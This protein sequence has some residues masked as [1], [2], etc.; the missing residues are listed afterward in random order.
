MQYI[1]NLLL[2]G[3]FI[4]S[5]AKNP[6][7]AVTI[8]EVFQTD[9]DETLDMDSP[10]VWHG[11]NGENWIITTAKKG[12]SLYVNDANSG[13]LVKM[14]GEK[15]T[16][17]NQFRRP[18]GIF[19]FEDHVFIVERDNRRVQVMALPSF[20]SIGVTGDSLLIKPYGLYI[21]QDSLK[22][23]HLYVTDNYETADEQ[24]PPISELDRRVHHYIFSIAG[25]TL[26]SQLVG[27]FGDTTETGALS[28]VESIHGDP[29][30]D[31]LLLSE[32]D[33]SQNVVKVYNINGKFTGKSFGQ[34]IFMSQ[35]EGI[36]LFVT[37][38]QTGYWII[39]DQSYTANRFHIFTREK[40]QHLGYFSGPKTTNTDGIWLTQKSFG[41]FKNGAFYA[42]HNDGN[43]SAFDFEEI[44]TAL[45]LSLMP[46]AQ[47]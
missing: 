45:N 10:A 21:Y 30:F 20:N 26:K 44:A 37:G 12:N 16:S 35:V 27:M 28:V 42:V 25:D 5:C 47:E 15:G 4:F 2:I 6:D 34:G 24:V 22:T 39:T 8:N 36:A 38:P 1:L 14:I 7:K 17:L 23:N 41:R 40:F 3:I 19:V 33:T 18:N 11:P 9:R 29:G 43:V 13:K 46:P 31:H 32:E